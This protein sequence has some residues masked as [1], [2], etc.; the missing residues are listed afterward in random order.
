MSKR[1]RYAGVLASGVL[2]MA[3]SLNAWAVIEEIVVTA[4]KRESDLQDTPIAI[5]AF[6]GDVIERNQIEDFRDIALRTPGLVFAQT[7]AMSIIALRGVGLDISSLGGETAIAA[8]RDGVYLGQSFTLSMPAFDLERIEVLRG[9]QGTLYGR[10]ATGGAVN[11]VTHGPSFEPDANL[12]LSYGDYDHIKIEVGGG[13]GLSDTVAARGSIVYDKR[14]DGY[15]NLVSLGRKTRGDESVVGNFSMLITPADDF[16]MTLRGNFS[17]SVTGFGTF[18]NLQFAPAGGTFLTPNNVG[19]FFTFP[20]PNFGGQSLAKVF[21]LDFPVAMAGNI[22]TDPDDL[23]VA[24]ELRNKQEFDVWGTSATIEW[25]LGEMMFKSITAYRDIQWKRLSDQDGTDLQLLTQDGIQGAETFTQEINLSGTSA[26]GRLDWLVG[27]YYFNEDASAEFLYDLRAFQLFYEALIGVFGTGSPLP[28][29]SLQSLSANNPLGRGIGR[30]QGQIS[31]WPFLHFTMEQDSKS[32]AAF[33]EGRYNLTEDFSLT[34]GARW[35][36]DE[37]DTTRS[38]SSN[39]VSLLAPAGLCIDS[40]DGDEWSEVTGNLIAEYRIEEDSLLFGKISRGYKAGGFN[41]G[42]CLGSFNPEIIW[43]YEAGLKTR[44]FDDQMQLNSAIFYYDYKDIQINRFINNAASVTNAAEAKL[45]GLETEFIIAPRAAEGLRLSGSIGYLDTKYEDATFADPIG[46]GPAIDVSGNDLLRA[47][48]WKFSLAAQ[49]GLRLG[50]T[51]EILLL[52]DVHY[53]DSYYF[54]VFEAGLPNQS[55]MEQGSYAI[56]NARI[57]WLPARGGYEVMVFVENIT[58]KL[59]AETRVA[60][61]TTG[62]VIGMFSR[63][64]TWGVRVSAKFGAG[65]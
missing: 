30:R 31:P 44:V 48:N 11:L 19:G 4:Q 26:T 54:D 58:D 35:T 25:D 5:T 37:K 15:R 7:D 14:G 65:R 59:Y 36:R 28:S 38:L 46:G 6:D 12:A 29:G 42:E 56:A 52:G 62:A 33:G 47:P 23:E 22:P 49:Y 50:D 32:Y 43:A 8:Y 1:G 51:G 2:G 10:N 41:P 27:G 40:P 55:E 16:D 63:P 3:L 53:S 45:F 60:V 34:L 9:P 24:G 64:R 18:E 13:T 20:D 39:F 21:N 61:G 17:D 57:S